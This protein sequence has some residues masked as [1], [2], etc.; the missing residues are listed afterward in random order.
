MVSQFLTALLFL[1]LTMPWEKSFA[2]QTDFHQRIIPNVSQR[3]TVY[4]NIVL[5]PSD[6]IHIEAGGCVQ[7]G[8]S[9]FTWKRYVNPSGENADRFYHDLI[10]I[11]G[12]T[13]KLQCIESCLNQDYTILEGSGGALKLGYEDNDYAD[14]SY[15]NSDNGTENQCAGE[16]NAYVDITIKRAAVTEAASSS[17]TPATNLG[18]IPAN[19]VIESDSSNST[20]GNNTVPPTGKPF[21]ETVLRMITAITGLL[22][23]VVGLVKVFKNK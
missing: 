9:G 7:S 10:F 16:Q 20:P 11:P 14:N 13:A 5:H 8:G 17:N 18:I 1:V 4:D 22:I 3:E 19:P 23:A 6:V 12:I 21:F 15:A 2:R